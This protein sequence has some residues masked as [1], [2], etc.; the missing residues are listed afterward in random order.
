MKVRCVIVDDLKDTPCPRPTCS[1]IL[2][3]QNSKQVG[4][5]SIQRYYYCNKCGSAPNDNKRVTPAGILTLEVD[6]AQYR[7][8]SASL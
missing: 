7:R 8:A 4:R 6:D 5:S 2:I 3:C 1:G